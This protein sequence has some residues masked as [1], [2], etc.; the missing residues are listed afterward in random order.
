M[1]NGR[2][3]SVASKKDSQTWSAVGSS[4]FHALPPLTESMALSDMATM[5]SR[6]RKPSSPNSDLKYSSSRRHQSLCA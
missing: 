2:L 1:S 5:Y 3:G 6:S 4:C